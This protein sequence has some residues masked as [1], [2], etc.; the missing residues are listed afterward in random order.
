MEAVMAKKDAQGFELDKNDFVKLTNHNAKLAQKKVDASAKEADG[1]KSSKTRKTLSAIREDDFAKND[2][3]QLIQ[4]EKKKNF[5]DGCLGIIKKINDTN[6]TRLSDEEQNFFA[7]YFNR[8][9]IEILGRIKL[10]DVDIVNYLALAGKNTSKKRFNLSFASKFC[11][12]ISRYAFNEYN[13]FTPYD[14][15]LQSI[16]PYYA[17]AYC[18]D[19]SVD[20]FKKDQDHGYSKYI[21][22]V[23]KIISSAANLYGAEEKLTLKEFDRLLWYKYKGLLGEDLIGLSNSS[24]IKEA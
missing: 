10:G 23:R 17:W 11:T 8:N 20:N 18:R 6:S 3:Y 24:L 12:Y 1:K 9:K 2:L 14:G 19:E 13:K 15:V 5:N 4:N 21:L 22:L 16:L 7:D